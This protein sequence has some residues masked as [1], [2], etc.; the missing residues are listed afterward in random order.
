[1]FLRPRGL[2][3]GS[4]RIAEAVVVCSYVNFLNHYIHPM[5]AKSEHCGYVSAVSIWHS[6]YAT[7]D[8]FVYSYYG[9]GSPD[10]NSYPPSL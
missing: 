8:A 4:F 7:G 5:L 9:V 1:M 10:S 6:R 2:V 3:F